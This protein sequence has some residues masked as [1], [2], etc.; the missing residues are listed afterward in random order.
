VRVADAILLAVVRP[1]GMDDGV[2]AGQHTAP[3]MLSRRF[4]WQ[5]RC[6]DPN[7]IAA[8]KVGF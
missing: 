8:L 4:T 7:G 2:L 1:G 3:L 5:Y 6:T